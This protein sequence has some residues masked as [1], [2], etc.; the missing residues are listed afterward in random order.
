VAKVRTQKRTET[1]AGAATT[2]IEQGNEMA[3]LT[4]SSEA[5]QLIVRALNLPP[6]TVAFTLRMRAGDPAM[7]EVETYANADVAEELATVLRRYRL[8]ELEEP[9]A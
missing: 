2:T 6:E 5:A 7:L 3:L 9:S 4:G 1:V 8:E